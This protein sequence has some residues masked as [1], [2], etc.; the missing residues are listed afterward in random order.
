MTAAHFESRFLNKQ[1][2]SIQML[3]KVSHD[4]KE[5][6][7]EENVFYHQSINFCE[8]YTYWFLTSVCLKAIERKSFTEWSYPGIST[9]HA[10]RR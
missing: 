1:L 10:L 2:F 7:G 5:L 8:Y 6:L 3:L 4:Y 9:T